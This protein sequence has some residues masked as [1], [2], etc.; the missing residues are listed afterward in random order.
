M[1]TPKLSKR[2][3][4]ISK[5]FV[6][7][8]LL[9][10]PLYP[11][12]PLFRIPG[13]YVSIRLEDFLMAAA[14]IILVI[15]IFPNLKN[16]IKDKINRAILIFLLVG[17]V[18][19]SSAL[20]ITQTV[21]FHLGMLHWLRR[22]E[23]FIPFFL[24]V[25][26]IRRKKENLEFFLKVLMITIL[27]VFVY[28]FGQRY[29]NWSIVVTQNEEYAKGVA[30]RYVAGSHINST[31]AGHYDLAS[32]LILLLPVY[33]SFF[34]LIKNIRTKALIALVVFSGLWL[35][36]YS[37][38]RISAASYLITVV[39][40]LLLIKK[41]KAI[42]FVVLIS[43]LFFGMSTN[44]VARY[45]RLIEVS[46]DKLQEINKLFFSPYQMDVYAVEET[47]TLPQRRGSSIPTPTPVPVFEDRSTS[48]R[49]NVE[50][51]RAIR[52]FSKNPLIGTGYSSI[53]LATDNDYLRLLGEVG[54]L[55]FFAFLL[56]FLRIGRYLLKS[57][58]PIKEYQG[59]ELAFMAGFMA[60]LPGIFL[61]A[62]F[63]DIFEASKFA[64]I[65]WLLAGFSVALIKNDKNN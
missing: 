27:L 36:A 5:Y 1:F 29:F 49:F 19:L 10:V 18:S 4:E 35:I 44:L 31:F 48:I 41:Y 40:S 45:Q 37:G 32:F 51:P 14:G 50:W 38:S 53:T 22:V 60:A 42:P 26:V 59:I 12:F 52:A 57:F 15:Y 20:F 9:A 25:I 33:I 7:A 30:L 58:P 13:T 64:I 23:Y 3:D 17:L 62:V 16:F 21:E 11:K 47:T 43:L 54:I 6:A 8:I 61:N 63:I 55:G 34:F 65:F 56:I 2:L 28:G 46:R 39:L 24:G